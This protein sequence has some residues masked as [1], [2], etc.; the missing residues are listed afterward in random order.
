MRISG[1]A[2]LLELVRR[3]STGAPADVQLT[4]EDSAAFD[5]L[6]TALRGR[7]V[8]VEPSGGPGGGRRIH[9]AG[10]NP[11]GTVAADLLRPHADVTTGTVDEG[12]VAD[13]DVL[14]SCASWLPDTEWRRV[15]E[16]CA[17]HGTAWHRCHAEGTRF[18]L[19]PFFLP[20]E[21]A[22][23]RDTRARRLA[24]CPVADELLEQWRYLD[25]DQP[26]PPVRWPDSGGGLLGALLAGD[27][28]ARLAGRPV[29][30]HGH[31]LLVDPDTAGITRHPV[32]PLP[33]LAE[34]LAPLAVP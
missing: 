2:P 1:P 30:S 11:V 10:D 28:L 18:A 22:G 19:G 8:L 13:A 21:T 15:D 27:V 6:V 14:V 33:R 9:V 31:Q 17:A 34:R 25:G 3:L 23:Y 20:G 29:P 7:G 16:W 26:K 5:Q 24:A 12:A 4:P 32:L